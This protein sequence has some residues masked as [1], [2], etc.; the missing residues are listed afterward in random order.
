MKFQE[1]QRRNNQPNEG[2]NWKRIK[3]QSKKLI[4]DEVVTRSQ[5]NLSDEVENLL[6]AFEKYWH[7]DLF[8]F[9][10]SEWVCFPRRIEMKPNT[11]E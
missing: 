8:I 5:A 4:M 7:K 3:P 6:R 2:S 10:W 1:Y 11:E 9:Y